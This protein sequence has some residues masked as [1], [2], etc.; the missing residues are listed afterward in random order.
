[1]ALPLSA[2]RRLTG[3]A[4]ARV[5]VPARMPCSVNA[6]GRQQHCCALR[7]MVQ[8]GRPGRRRGIAPNPSQQPSVRP[9]TGAENRPS[10]KFASSLSSALF[11]SKIGAT[12][13]KMLSG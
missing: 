10:Y 5:L 3:H 6:P 12:I 4:S 13:C 1:M 7:F 11:M 8:P 2:I 9:G